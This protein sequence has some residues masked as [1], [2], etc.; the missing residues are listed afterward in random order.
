MRWDI[1]PKDF[2]RCGDQSHNIPHYHLPPK[3]LAYFFLAYSVHC[4]PKRGVTA[5]SLLTLR[6]GVISIKYIE[7]QA[8]N[9]RQLFQIKKGAQNGPVIIV[10]NMIQL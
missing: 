8:S 7:N 5:L 1:L 3:A 9:K 6:S 4:S 10:C 2:K